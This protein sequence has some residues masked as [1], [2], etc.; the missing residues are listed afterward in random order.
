[1]HF[2]RVLVGKMKSSVDFAQ[3]IHKGIDFASNRRFNS[4][5]SVVLM[6]LPAPAAL[7]FT[8]NVWLMYG[9]VAQTPSVCSPSAK[10]QKL[11]VFSHLLF[12]RVG[13]PTVCW[14][15]HHAPPPSMVPQERSFY[16]QH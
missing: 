7:V 15:G 9:S 5:L 16:E 8:M 13:D 11:Q 14:F 2:A 12:A 1:M 10:R 6:A 4:A 3:T